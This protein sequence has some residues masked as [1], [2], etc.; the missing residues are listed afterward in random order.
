MIQRRQHV[1]RRRVPLLG[2]LAIPRDGLIQIGLHAATE[3]QHHRE[4]ILR[5]RQALVRG[6]F[7]PTQS[8]RKILFCAAPLFVKCA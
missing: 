5:P 3:M 7:V 6:Q 8:R 1:L 4:V 2:R